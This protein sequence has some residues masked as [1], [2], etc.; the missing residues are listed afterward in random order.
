MFGRKVADPE[1]GWSLLLALAGLIVGGAMVGL[2]AIGTH[3]TWVVLTGA[4]IA[5][6]GYTVF[7]RW[8]AAN[9]H[10]SN[11]L[12]FLERIRCCI[13]YEGDPGPLPQR[14]GA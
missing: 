8:V 13:A 4:L 3:E 7:W 6:S 12:W 1:P 5:F 2:G 10:R 14:D 9:K 11:L